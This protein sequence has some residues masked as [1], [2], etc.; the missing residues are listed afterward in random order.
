MKKSQLETVK[1]RQSSTALLEQEKKDL[2]RSLHRLES[3]FSCDVVQYDSK[4][5]Q[6][7]SVV[8]DLENLNSFEINTKLDNLEINRKRMDSA[9][10][11]LQSASGKP[12]NKSNSQVESPIQMATSCSPCI[13]AQVVNTDEQNRPMQGEVTKKVPQP[14]LSRS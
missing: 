13:S 14:Y 12:P 8:K 9:I 7:T 10:N 1:Q 5:K 4:L 6:I 11:R 2:K 3:E